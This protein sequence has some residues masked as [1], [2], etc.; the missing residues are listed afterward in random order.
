MDIVNKLRNKKNCSITDNIEPE[1]WY[2]WF[3]QLNRAPNIP[4]SFDK[5][6]QNIITRVKDF[7]LPNNLLDGEILNKEIIK[8]AKKLKNGKAVSD[9]VSNEMIKCLVH[10]KFVDIRDLFNA[11]YKGSHFPNLWK[12][13]YITPTFKNEDSFDLSNYRGIS[14]CSCLGK[15]FTLV[16]NE[17]LLKFLREKNILSYNQIGSEGN[18]EQLIIYL[19]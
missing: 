3:K 10:T 2:E 6:S 12:L 4:D 11:I 15:P 18:I 1:E 17:R 5:T 9:I 19:S 14:V 16:I 8:A 7:T 13:G